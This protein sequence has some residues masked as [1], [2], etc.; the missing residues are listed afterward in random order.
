M[1][2]VV[3]KSPLQT[4]AKVNLTNDVKYLLVFVSEKK[5]F[6]RIPVDESIRLPVFQI[7]CKSSE[8]FYFSFLVLRIFSRFCQILFGDG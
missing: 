2:I 6:L 3:L 1:E 4:F 5:T 8:T 7:F